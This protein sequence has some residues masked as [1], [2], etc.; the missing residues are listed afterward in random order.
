MTRDQEIYDRHPGL[1][2]AVVDRQVA[3][4]K[5]GS[6]KL[7]TRNVPGLN[8]AEVRQLARIEIEK[9]K[10][11]TIY[12]YSEREQQHLLW[13]DCDSLN[14]LTED[15]GKGEPD[16]RVELPDQ[17]EEA[18]PLRRRKK[19]V[20]P[21]DDPVDGSVS[22]ETVSG[23]GPVRDV[24]EEKQPRA[25]GVRRRDSQRAAPP[26]RVGRALELDG[27]NAE[28]WPKSEGAQIVRAALERVGR[29]TVAELTAMLAADLAKAGVGFPGSLISRLKQGGFLKEVTA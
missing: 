2:H 6:I 17:R 15:D 10:S 29:A 26:R 21:V 16:G 9:D 23:D 25:E 4:K 20:R 7:E 28:R 3:G 8:A 5:D 22:A 24:P 1:Y 11:V 18:A 13:Y 27:G 12:V 19:S 14:F